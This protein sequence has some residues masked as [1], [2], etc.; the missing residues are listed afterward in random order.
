V[1]VLAKGGRVVTVAT[2]SGKSLSQRVRNAFLLLQADG[3]QLGEIANL[4]DARHLRIS[5]GAIFPWS[6][7]SGPTRWRGRAAGA[8]GRAACRCLTPI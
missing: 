5:V 3:S 2:T 6:S 8:E 7:A 4:I 1:G